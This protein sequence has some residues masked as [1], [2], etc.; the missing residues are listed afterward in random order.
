MHA[1]AHVPSNRNTILR[2]HVFSQVSVSL[3]RFQAFVILKLLAY[4]LHIV[5]TLKVFVAL[6]C[7]F[8]RT[9]YCAMHLGMVATSGAA[10]GCFITRLIFGE[11]PADIRCR[12]G[13]PR[14]P[15]IGTRLSAQGSFRGVTTSSVLLATLRIEEPRS[16]ALRHKRGFP[17]L[18][19]EG[20]EP[21]K[22]KRA[23]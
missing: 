15:P 6:A 23:A 11:A 12:R 4:E 10:A 9:S 22:Q 14:F 3:V 1:I 7:S 13:P 8:L 20:N 17:P 2:H 18:F 19:P 16:P 21:K 5:K